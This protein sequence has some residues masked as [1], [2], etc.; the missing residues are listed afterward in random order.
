MVSTHYALQVLL[1][2]LGCISNWSH[3]CWYQAKDNI[4]TAVENEEKKCS[5]RLDN[6]CLTLGD[7]KLRFE[8]NLEAFDWLKLN[9]TA[10][11]KPQR[12]TQVQFRL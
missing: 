2:Q 4:R 6:P 1:N 12:K 9:S 3:M 5:A 10:D 7:V 8:S 11:C